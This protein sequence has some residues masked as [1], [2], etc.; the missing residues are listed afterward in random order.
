MSWV[1]LDDKL[2]SHPKVIAA[3]NAAVGAW[4]RMLAYAGLHLTDGRVPSAVA[5][6]IASPRELAMLLKVGLVILLEDGDYYL[7]DFL[8][9][10]PPASEVKARRDHE[11][12]RKQRQR[13]SVPAY[14]PPGQSGVSRRLSHRDTNDVPP[15]VPP[16]QAHVSRGDSVR[17][18]GRASPVPSREEEI[19]SAS[20]SPLQD[21]HSELPRQPALARVLE[22]SKGNPEFEARRAKQLA[23]LDRLSEDPSFQPARKAGAS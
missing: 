21:P 5:K 16:G 14:V 4:V 7:H 12:D 2:T 11:R 10:N 9:W 13:G 17:P 1:K 3:G 22:N 8:E 6:S 19:S 20:E 23:D 18:R 15:V